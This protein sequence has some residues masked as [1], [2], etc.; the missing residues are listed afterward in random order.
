MQTDRW[1]GRQRDRQL[2]DFFFS[3]F[4]ESAQK[5]TDIAPSK[6]PNLKTEDMSLYCLVGAVA[7]VH[8]RFQLFS[9]S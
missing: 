6:S 7:H 1:T 9:E 2:L 8:F 4:C 5:E 3:K